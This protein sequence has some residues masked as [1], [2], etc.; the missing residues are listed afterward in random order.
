VD[1]AFSGSGTISGNLFANDTDTDFG[2]GGKTRW[3]VVIVNASGV[4]VAAP[5]GLSVNADGTFSYAAANGSRTFYYRI[6]TGV[7]TDGAA[8]ADMSLDSNVAAVT[9]T[10]ING[11]PVFP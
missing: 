3:R 10:V 1:D 11:P 5:P 2:P 9:L 8:T 4:P 6:D 7:W